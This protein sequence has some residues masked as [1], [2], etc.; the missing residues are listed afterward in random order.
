MGTN[1]YLLCSARI[2]L[3]SDLPLKVNL[4]FVSDKDEI[5]NELFIPYKLPAEQEQIINLN[6]IIEI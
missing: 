1:I 6:R 4:A 3:K 2:A 5:K